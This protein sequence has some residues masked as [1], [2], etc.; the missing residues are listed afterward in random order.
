[1]S[2]TTL[3]SA[4]GRVTLEDVQNALADTDPNATN[5]GKV[6]ALLGGRGSFE[7]I[8]KHLKTLREQQ[9][10]AAMPPSAPADVPAVPPEVAN[11]VWQAAWRAAQ[12]QTFQR[13]EKLA[14]QRDAAIDQLNTMNQDTIGLVAQLDEQAVQ[15]DRAAQAVASIQAAH[16]VDLD[17]AKAEQAKAAQHAAELAQELERTR[18]EMAQQKTAATH[19]AELADSGR[20][21][22]RE[23]LARLTDQVGELKSHLYKRADSAPTA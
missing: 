2:E 7:T 15:L 13:L 4:A 23:E 17:K 1:M 20:V 22:M 10:E 3:P 11:Q 5:A 8:Q 9:A 14:T 6:R 12:V 19:A 21:M 18:K 16:L